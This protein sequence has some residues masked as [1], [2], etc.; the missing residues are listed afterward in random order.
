V[1]IFRPLTILCV[2]ALSAHALADDSA[3]TLSGFGTVGAVETNTNDAK[4]VTGTVQS[5]G[6]GKSLDFGVDTKLGVQAGYKAT[7]SLT[8]TLQL[9][10]TK[11]RDNNFNPGVEWANVKYD[12]T[13]NF[14]IRGG[15]I[16]APFFLVSDFRNVGYANTWVRPPVE[17]YGQ[18]PISSIDGI[19]AIWRVPVGENTLTVQPYYGT[20]RFKLIG[21]RDGKAKNTSGLN[22][23]YEMDSWTFRGGYTATSLTVASPSETALLGAINQTAAAVAPLS[24]ALSGSLTGLANNLNVS[25]KHSTFAGVGASY[26]AGGL[27][28]QSEYTQRRT[29][30]LVANTNAWYA[31]FGYHFGNFTPYLSYAKI[32]TQDRHQ[33]DAIPTSGL[34]APLLPVMGALHAAVA[35]A[36]EGYDQHNTTLGVRWNAYKNLDLKLQYERIETE[37]GK[38]N[39]FI[40][41]TPSFA[42]SSVNVYSL[43]ADFVF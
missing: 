5:S 29:D 31:T 3:L 10:S 17:V 42:G 4:Y 26:D 18:V 38:G 13:S 43:A 24:P 22:M 2:A 12:L 16:G 37:A 23:T 6:V 27:V 30:S 9:L 33:E 21:D 34:P 7:P 19:D 11:N 28:F 32:A 20:G 41:A 8:A 36:V 35:G 25:S 14:A 39:Y 15:R 1:A 40:Q